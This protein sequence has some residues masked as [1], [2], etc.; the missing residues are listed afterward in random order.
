MRSTVRLDLLVI[1]INHLHIMC[2]VRFGLTGIYFDSLEPSRPREEFT[3]PL[4]VSVPPV[5]HN[6]HGDVGP[7]AMRGGETQ[8][9]VNVATEAPNENQDCA[10][11][12]PCDSSSSSFRDE[13]CLS[14]KNL[15]T[16]HGSVGSKRVR[17][18]VPSSSSSTSSASPS[19]SID[20]VPIHA[21]ANSKINLQA[22]KH[23]KLIDLRKSPK[24]NYHLSKRHTST[25]PER[26]T[27][28]PPRKRVRFAMDEHESITL[29]HGVGSTS[30]SHSSDDSYTDPPSPGEPCDPFR[31]YYRRQ[32]A[33]NLYDTN[34]QR[35]GWGTQVAAEVAISEAA[36]E[37]DDYD[38][39]LNSEDG[40]EVDVQALPVQE[41]P[42]RTMQASVGGPK[43]YQ[44]HH[45][46]KTSPTAWSKQSGRVRD[47]SRVVA[48]ADEENVDI[49]LHLE[50]SHA[51]QRESVLQSQSL[52]RLHYPKLRSGKGLP[53]PI[54]VIRPR[55]LSN[56]KGKGRPAGVSS[57][58]RYCRDISKNRQQG[59]KGPPSCL[60]EAKAP[61]QNKPPI[62]R[63]P[64]IT[65]D[66]KKDVVFDVGLDMLVRDV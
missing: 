16:I 40:S 44:R 17:N 14:A 48:Q 20:E 38:D 63:P 36:T 50:E 19:P 56:V 4:I 13:G 52:E 11:E 32:A 59:T 37:M 35:A 31:G 64:S 49:G 41:Y 24:N 9:Q 15:Q 58:G 28:A 3:Q 61:D 60:T 2:R 23:S 7:K 30:S 10:T 1:F 57:G 39:F 62:Y 29:G 51:N 53:E 65:D 45:Q 8:E 22:P 12:N 27:K 21:L 33:S 55:F 66:L 43:S 26:P 34:G 47:E 42:R 5:L 46:G 18:S 54:F 25:S 6:K